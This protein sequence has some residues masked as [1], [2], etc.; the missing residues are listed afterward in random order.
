MHDQLSSLIFDIRKSYR[1]TLQNDDLCEKQKI[2]MGSAWDKT[3]AYVDPIITA[4]SFRLLNLSG[5][6]T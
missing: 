4:E 5:V 2:Q 3:S 1:V 6:Y